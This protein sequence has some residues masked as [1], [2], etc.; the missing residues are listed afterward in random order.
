MIRMTL[1]LIEPIV[2]DVVG[3]RLVSAIKPDGYRVE[4]RCVGWSKNIHDESVQFDIVAT[5]MSPK[6]APPGGAP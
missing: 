4:A 2:H 5:I 3:Q 6:A 1:L